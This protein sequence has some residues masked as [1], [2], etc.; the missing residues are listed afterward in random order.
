MVDVGGE[1]FVFWFYRT[2]EH[3]FLDAFSKKLVFVQQMVFLFSRKVEESWP[4]GLPS[5]VDP[6]TLQFGCCQSVM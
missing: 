3:V 5:C 6:V 4:P 1:N 2:Q